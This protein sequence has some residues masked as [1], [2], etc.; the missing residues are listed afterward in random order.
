[1]H[2]LVYHRTLTL[3]VLTG[4]CNWAFAEQLYIEKYGATEGTPTNSGFVFWDGK[5]VPAPYQ[6]SRRGL[7]IYINDLRIVK[8]TRHPQSPPLTDG[9]D[10]SRLSDESR[11]K[12]CRQLEATRGIYEKYLGRNYGYI[13]DS[14]GGHVR[15]LPYT[16]AYSLPEVIKYIHSDRAREEQLRA[17]KRYKW[18]FYINIDKFADSFEVSPQFWQKVNELSRKLLLVEEYGTDVQVIDKG[19]VFYEGKYWDCPYT[20]ERR[21]LGLFLNDKLIAPMY[22]RPWAE[23]NGAVDPEMPAEITDESSIYDE[24]VETYIREK[25]AYLREHKT[26]DEEKKAMFDVYRSLP[27]VAE[28]ELHEYHSQ[29]DPDIAQVTT[30][31]GLKVLMSLA[32]RRKY[33]AQQER[34]KFDEKDAADATFERLVKVLEENKIVLFYETPGEKRTNYRRFDTKKLPEILD[35]VESDMTFD[36]KRSYVSQILND[37]SDTSEEMVRQFISGF[38]VSAQLEQRLI[39][40]MGNKK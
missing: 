29:P 25:H 18:H 23:P 39:Q 13:F 7:A 21:G 40:L 20:V 35:A 28:V 11:D 1:M 15:M 5:Y 33:R 31:S 2:F 34:R 22:I 36:D 17:I 37:Q 30:T 27:C 26:E 8:P 3:F 9:N 6:V 16:V 19:F 32:S 10:L 4:L 38:S 24:A 14:S 12:L